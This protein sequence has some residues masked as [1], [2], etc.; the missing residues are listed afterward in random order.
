M[1]RHRL[2]TSA[3]TILE[4]SVGGG[5]M[6]STTA[7][8]NLWPARRPHQPHF[9][10]AA[11]PEVV[12]GPAGLRV[13]VNVPRS[14]GASGWPAGAFGI[15][16]FCFRRPR[17]TSGAPVLAEGAEA[18]VRFERQ[19]IGNARK[20]S[21]LA[22]RGIPIGARPVTFLG[23]VVEFNIENRPRT[24]IQIPRGTGRV[25]ERARPKTPG[26]PPR[27]QRRFDR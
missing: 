12:D 10:S 20:L 11:W 24:K 13:G 4:H 2:L 9:N 18:P 3:A 19:H 27:G 17:Q 8:G 21:G 5:R 16:T 14:T 25:H 6:E 1:A 7:A 22:G 15:V 26:C 23:R